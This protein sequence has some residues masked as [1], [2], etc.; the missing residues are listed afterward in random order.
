[1]NNQ[2]DDAAIFDQ[3]SPPSILSRRSLLK[4]M[5]AATFGMMPGVRSLTQAQQAEA[6]RQAIGKDHRMVV[7][8][9]RP[10]VLETPLELLREH[11]L[12]PKQ[13]LFVR[14]NQLWD[15]AL[16][17][18]PLPL[19]GWRVEMIGLLKYP[20]VIQGSEL[21]RYQPVEVEMVLQCSGNGRSYYADT[22]KTRGTQWQKGGMG[23]LRWKGVPLKT[24]VEGLKLEVDS[25]ARFITAEGQDVPP[26]DKAADFEHSVP[27][28]EALD[29]AILALEMNG[30]PIP[31]VHGGPVRLIIPGY[32]GTMNVKWLT[33][34]R[35][36]AEESG[37]YNHIPRYRTFKRPIEPG[38]N[39][40]KTLENTRPTWRQRINSTIWSPTDGQQLQA[41]GLKLR[42]VAWN[43]G[44]VKLEAVE[45][46]TNQGR[47]WERAR[48]EVPSDPF[49]WHH[50]EALLDLPSGRH[51][52]WAR[53]VDATGQ[54]Q[55]LDGSIHWNPSGYE[56]NGIA[57]VEVI[58]E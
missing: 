11:R 28:D 50:W 4:W 54:G 35:F 10:G 18:D 32:Y 36:E 42:G 44:V 8:N 51:Q 37:N 41:G 15:G 38:T 40:P 27:I 12:T 30:E 45:V 46:S 7:H 17:A 33:R 20:R 22:I 21:K 23:N 26:S 39:P 47:T 5:G 56:W 3:S 58:A 53:A 29:R 16:S 55:P 49:A 13:I 25:R 34:L 6:F 24:L 2:P 9:W 43:D 14:N 57:R 1:M 31:A 52:I 19:E 48:L